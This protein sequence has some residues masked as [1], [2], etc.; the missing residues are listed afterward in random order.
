MNCYVGGDMRP[1]K[2]RYILA[3]LPKFW[4]KNS[5]LGSAD[6]KQKFLL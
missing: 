3:A 2:H 6:S 1:I 5:V 4:V